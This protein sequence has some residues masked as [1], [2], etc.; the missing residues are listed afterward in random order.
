MEGEDDQ[1]RPLTKLA[2]QGDMDG[3][4]HGLTDLATRQEPASKLQRAVSLTIVAAFHENQVPVSAA[5][6]AWTVSNSVVLSPSVLREVLWTGAALERWEGLKSVVGSGMGTGGIAEDGTSLLALAAEANQPEL[7]NQIL[8]LGPSEAE[9]VSA[10]RTDGSGATPVLVA[11]ESGSRDALEVLIQ[12]GGDVNVVSEDTG[13]TPLFMAAVRGHA[14]TV[15]VLLNAGAAVDAPERQSGA[16]ALV[17]AASIGSVETVKTLIKAGAK[18]NATAA[19]N[20]A[21]ACWAAALSGHSDVIR[22]LVDAEADIELKASEPN[23]TPLWISCAKGNIEAVQ[24]LLK[25]GASTDP[26]CADGQ[27]A[28]DVATEG[29]HKDVI[30]ALKHHNHHHHHHSSS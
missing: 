17:A 8:S 22:V 13:A 26:V 12:H 6:A 16:T 4:L 24:E 30:A 2:I 11:A 15:A 25:A 7:I 20:G 1:L 9:A 14:Q 5:V 29:G 23:S 10:P 19:S 28:M 18:V 27:T 3:V 21:T